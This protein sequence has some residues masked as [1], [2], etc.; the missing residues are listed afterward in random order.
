MY[1]P[2]LAVII[3]F[4]IVYFTKVSLPVAYADY[5]SIAILVGVDSGCGGIRAALEGQFDDTMFVT[6][7]F[8][9]AVLAVFL[10][11]VGDILGVELYLAVVVALGIR[12]FRNLGII[13]SILIKRTLEHRKV[14]PDSIAGPQGGGH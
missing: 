10:A 3:G 7:F 1:L 9:N 8:T 6:G 4:L 2:I 11:Y 12:I 14:P 13:R 5:V